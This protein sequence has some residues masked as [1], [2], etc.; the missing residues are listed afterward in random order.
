MSTTCLIPLHV[1]KG[2]SVREAFDRIIGYVENPGKTENGKLISSYQC[3]G[4]MASAEFLLARNLYIQ[5]TGRTRRTDDVIAYHI[6]QSFVPGEITPEEANRLGQELAMRFTKGRNAFLVC[7]HTDKA[8]VHNHIILSAVTT[9]HTRK[10]R[11]FWGSSKAIRRLN[12]TICI[13]NGYSIVEAPQGHGKSYDKWL[14]D[15]AKPSHRETICAAIDQALA[16]K[17]DS[18]DELLSLLRQVGYEIKGSANP[19]LRGGT[20]KRFIRMDTLD[21]G[22]SAGEL[23]EVIAGTKQHT[24]RKQKSREPKKPQK[25]NQLLIDIQTKLAQGKGTGYANWAKKFNLKQMAQTVAYLQEH[26]LMDY[27]VLSEKATQASAR[28]N[29]LSERIKSAERRMAEIS[30]LR[31]QIINYAR[32]REVYVAYHKAGYSKQFLAEHEG[33][34]TLHKASKKYFDRLGLKKLPTVKALNAEYAKL[35]ADKKAA[36]AEYRKAR[37]EMKDLL[38]AKSNI[39]QILGV[40]GRGKTTQKEKEAEQ[41]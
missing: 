14:G 37:E 15:R 25:R 6:R 9:D 10:L 4:P 26:D 38:T 24:L 12:D 16:Q 22:Y 17:P 19:S 27:A 8:H 7:T 20:Q 40:D 18:F 31:T 11:N 41:R 34:I 36:Y 3:T 35:L 23:R 30:V 21:P 32:T 28:F 13:Q 39:D 1:G 33:D 29:D 2:Q 5:K